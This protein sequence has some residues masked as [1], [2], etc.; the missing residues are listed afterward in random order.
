LTAT[1]LDLLASGQ[2]NIFSLLALVSEG[3]KQCSIAVS[4]HF[5]LIKL[6]NACLTHIVIRQDFGLSL[7]ERKAVTCKI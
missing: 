6:M 3:S 1:K 5:Y 4:W 7:V 2:F